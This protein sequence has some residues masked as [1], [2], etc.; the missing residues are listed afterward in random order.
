[1]LS[2]KKTCSPVLLEVTSSPTFPQAPINSLPY[3]LGLG[4][5][6]VLACHACYHVSPGRVTHNSELLPKKKR[7]TQVPI[8]LFE[9]PCP[10]C[11]PAPETEKAE[12]G[13]LKQG[14]GN[15]AEMK[16]KSEAP[17]LGT[18]L[19]SPSTNILLVQASSLTSCYE[20]ATEL[21]LLCL[22]VAHLS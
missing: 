18:T 12:E 11:I 14:T 13:R 4:G 1:M 7:K 5:I 22:E 21:P 8:P 15:K 20:V 3:Q 9:Q 16:S 19:Y 6:T 17:S 2:L 10:Q